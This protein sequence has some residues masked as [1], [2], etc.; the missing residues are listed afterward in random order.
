VTLGKI[1]P[2]SSAR[3]SPTFSIGNTL[4]YLQGG[5]NVDWDV[6]AGSRYLELCHALEK[7]HEPPP[8]RPGRHKDTTNMPIVCKQGQDTPPTS[9]N[10]RHSND[11][12]SPQS[13]N[14]KEVSP[15]SDCADRRSPST[16]S[17]LRFTR[18]DSLSDYLGMSVLT[19]SSKNKTLS[20]ET[21]GRLVWFSRGRQTSASRRSTTIF[22]SSICPLWV[23]N[24]LYSLKLWLPS[25]R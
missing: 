15:G 4:H 19:A 11:G 16:D 5:I 17:L 22:L 13:L 14:L 6:D 25:R 3:V 1:V 10:G 2:V 20:R 12:G 8:T 21:L 9:E 7:L 18:R 24:L 23:T